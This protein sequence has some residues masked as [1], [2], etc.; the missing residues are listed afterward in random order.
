MAKRSDLQPISLIKSTFRNELATKQLLAEFIINSTRLSMGEQCHSFEQAFSSYQG[1]AFSI[2]CNSGSSA[3]LA[4]IQTLL[5]LGRLQRNDKVAFSALTWSTNVMPLFQLGLR[6]IPV[7]I[8]RESINVGSRQF[9]E[10]L[11]RDPDIKAFFITNILG[12]CDDIDTIATICRERQI[13]LI[14]DNCESL[15]SV[16]K[17]RKLGNYGA[18]STFST[19]VGHHLSTIEGGVVATDDDEIASMLKMVRAHGWDRSLEASEQATL[20]TRHGVDEFYDLY[21][22][23]DLGYN[24]RPTEITG[25][26]GLLQLKCADEIVN[27]REK[28]YLQL[29]RAA[30]SNPAL[31]PVSGDHMDLV[32]NF[33]YPVICRTR[34]LFD[35]CRERAIAA[36]VEIR[37][38]VGGNMTNQPFFRKY[39][40]TPWVLP[41][42]DFVHDH[43]FY[44]P[45]NPELTDDEI[46]RMTALLEE[47]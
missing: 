6:P 34:E 33:A 37:P 39:Q 18:A 40:Q 9:A 10:A 16:Y 21:T 15:G 31:L 25:F 5:N 36:G 46:A 43:G 13:I 44:L 24:L 14:E 17:G 12:F 4:L 26:I 23:Y 3:N 2:L 11:E 7:D 47:I 27:A 42:A 29:N 20:R 32:S 22:F 28:N 38:I 1:R 30:R 8:S 19:F 45:N 35:A 41:N